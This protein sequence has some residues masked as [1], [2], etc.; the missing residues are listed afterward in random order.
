MPFVPDIVGDELDRQ[1]A[2]WLEAHV[3]AEAGPIAS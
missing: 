1:L 2:Q 3:F